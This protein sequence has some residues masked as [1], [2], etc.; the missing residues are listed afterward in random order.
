[1]PI[2]HNQTKIVLVAILVVSTSYLHYIT[3][4]SQIY[5]HIFYRELYF[6][7]LILAGFWFGLRGG[8]ITSLSITAF[9]LPFSL[10]HW[11]GF[12]LDDFDKIVE[13]LLYNIVAVTL[14]TLRD[15]L[16]VERKR[17]IEAEGLTAMGKALSAVAHE[18]KTPLTAIGGFTRLVQKKL[19]EDDPNREKLDI[20]IRETQRLENM[21]KEMMDFSRPLELRRAYEDV[22]QV[23]TESLSIVTNEAR[24]RKVKIESQLSHDLPLASFDAP[25]ME[26]VLINLVMN[27]V[28]ASPEGEIVM[29]RTSQEKENICIDVTDCGPGIPQDQREKIFVPFFTT[30]KGGTGLGLPIVKKIVE[31]H[32]GSLEVLD[33]AKKG[34]TFRVLLSRLK[35]D[36]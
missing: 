28:Q 19:K 12:S 33:N 7:P 11:S 36:I 29:V 14:G 4:E 23:V 5:Y 15:R 22:N 8:L 18:M 34:V 2:K 35:Q 10:V 31:A 13:I 25:R 21:V 26:Q 9:Y 30:K 1:M 3:R 17:L 16:S 20:V 6:L 27:A 32:G 24:E